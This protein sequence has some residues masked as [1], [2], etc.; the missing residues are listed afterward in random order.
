[1]SARLE[2]YTAVLENTGKLSDR[3]QTTNDIFVGLNS[4]VLTALGFLFVSSA[5]NF[6]NW[7]LP[8][9]FLAVTLFSTVINAIWLS[10]NKRYRAL[11]GIRIAYLTAL[12]QELEQSGELRPVTVTIDKKTVKAAGVHQLEAQSPLYA[13]G[14]TVGFSSLEQRIIFS[15][16]C[17]YFL[18]T[19]IVAGLHVLV[20]YGYITP[21]NFP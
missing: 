5:K 7:W 18:A 21:P 1:M 15:F 11:V 20:Q 19:I 10:L 9:M 16:I 14:P 4:L 3:R 13:G 12:E 17:T 6:Y 2:E 8:G